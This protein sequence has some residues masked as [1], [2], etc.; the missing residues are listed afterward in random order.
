MGRLDELNGPGSYQ[1]PTLAAATRFAQTHK[2]KAPQRRIEIH[3]PDGR[4]WDGKQ[5]RSEQ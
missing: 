5:W 1:F 4:V 3:F 2:A